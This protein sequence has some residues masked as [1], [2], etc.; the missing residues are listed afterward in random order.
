MPADADPLILA[1]APNGA[2][3]TP[4]D[5]PAVPVSADEIGRTAAACAAAG[6][7]MIHA[8]VR[9]ADMRH[10]LDAEAYRDAIAAIRREAGAD[11]IIQITTEAAGRYAAPAQMAVVRE[12]MPEACSASIRELA[13]EEAAEPA[14]ADFFQWAAASDIHVQYILY[15][16]DDLQ[17]FVDLHRRGLI[18]QARPCLLYVLGRYSADQQSVPAD[19]LPFLDLDLPFDADWFVCAFG[20]QEAGCALTAAA[21]GGH[22]RIGFENNTLLANG[23]TAPDNASL[24]RQLAPGAGILGREIADAAAARDLLGIGRR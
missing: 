6:A 3:K 14:A 11:I 13:G 23:E 1:I 17:R 7:A 8:H 24:V 21:L 22:A 10:L 4:A 15:N 18:P 16:P 5:H 2:R 9:D 19:L 12:T 20:R